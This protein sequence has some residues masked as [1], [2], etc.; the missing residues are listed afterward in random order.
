MEKNKI[1]NQIE[2]NRLA[3]LDY[4]FII[5]QLCVL[6]NKPFEDMKQA[7]DELIVEGAF[8]LKSAVAVEESAPAFPYA[9][10]SKK[11]NDLVA[12]A[13][14]MLYR[15][16]KKRESKNKSFKLQ[17]KLQGTKSGF[18]FLIPFDKTYEDVF[19]AG[20]DLNG[21]INNDTVV[22]EV[23][24]ERDG[25]RYEGRVIQILE[26]GNERIVGKIFLSKGNAMVMP[27]DVKFGKDILVP[28]SKVMDANNGDKVVVKITNYAN[29]KNPTGEVIEVLG[30]PNKIETEVKAIIRSYDLYE[31]FP[32]K[33]KE[34]A[35]TM[36]EYVQKEKYPTRKDLTDLNCFTIDGEDSRDLD[37]AISISMNSNGTYKLGVHIADVGEYVTYNNALDKEAFKRGTSVYFPNLVLPMLPRELSN[38]I[39]S[40][41]EGV[42]R[43]ALSVFM[44]IDNKG[45]IKNYEIC[46]SVIRSK[47]RFTYTLVTK[48]LDNDEQAC[49][50]N[51]QFVK[52]LRL[53]NELSKILIKMREARGA[54]DFDIP[55]VKITLNELGDVLNVE[56]APRDDSHRLI[57]S[58]MIAAN[59]AVATHY[60]KIKAPFVYRIHE[61]PDTEKM[62]NFIRIA[63]GM[64]V[65][66]TVNV[67]NVAPLDLQKILTQ[68]A[69]MDCK[70]MLNRICLRSMK[71]AKYSPD[72]LGHYGIASLKYCHFTSPIRRYPDLTIHRIIK[73][74]LRGE[75]TGKLLTDQRHFVVASSMHSSDR[76][77]A[78]EKVERDVD[79]LYKVFYMTHH[80]GEEFEGKISG[81]TNFGV[82]VE[83]DNTVEGMVRISDLPRDS[84]EYDENDFV[85][86]G[87]K[88]KYVIGNT[89][90]VKCVRADIL[91]R[92]ID[93]VLV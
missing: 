3:E 90:K 61:T 29:K 35:Q 70:Y 26:R 92:E 5:A 2:V 82:F 87:A 23:K 47:K 62:A 44:D 88:E 54:I 66:T 79:D 27:D 21:A 46:E 84:Y 17:G 4:E 22:A 11:H 72:C 7:L 31:D 6:N 10:N 34:F 77:Q 42:D 91:A 28:I 76:E 83:L 74:D 59:E 38:G 41:N 81:V 67:E 25:K 57:E 8:K 63:V 18:A 16:D 14:E 68:I 37:D 48:I 32:K 56:K 89:V 9:K 43:L 12:E 52:D 13:E 64:G 93:F 65:K 45:E 20:S 19:I 53:M 86:K 50:E 36:P 33:V 73:A 78:A 40:L 80:I 1:L 15:K 55:E 60:N 58:F 71:K 75:L 85:L 24:R 49:A 69:E 39:C 51:Q 30:A